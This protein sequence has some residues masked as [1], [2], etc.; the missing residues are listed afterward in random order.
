VRQHQT[1]PPAELRTMAAT[2]WQA[3]VALTAEG[4]TEAQAIALI[5]E[6]MANAQLAAE[7][8]DD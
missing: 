7:L 3:F 5:G 2:L 8:D 1:E 6:M 4:F